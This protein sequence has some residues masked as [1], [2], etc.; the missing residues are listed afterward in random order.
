MFLP[1][2]NQENQTHTRL[3]FLIVI[4]RTLLQMIKSF[5]GFFGVKITPQTT[6]GIAYGIKWIMTGILLIVGVYTFLYFLRHFITFVRTLDRSY[7][8]Q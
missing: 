6:G 2:E 3:F 4:V 8:D 7:I 1:T 5:F